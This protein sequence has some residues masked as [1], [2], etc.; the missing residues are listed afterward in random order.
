MQNT[1]PN[2]SLY[3]LDLPWGIDLLDL[4]TQP[5][6]QLSGLANGARRQRVHR[7]LG[8]RGQRGGGDPQPGGGGP[9]VIAAACA[10]GCA[11]GG[12]QLASPTS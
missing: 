5:T 6:Q 8:N 7:R 9:P 12:A 2:S 3:A 10:K 4:V 11:G 1:A